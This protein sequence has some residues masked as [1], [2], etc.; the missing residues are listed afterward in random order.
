MSVDT[1][2]LWVRRVSRKWN[3]L[4]NGVKR[5]FSNGTP[6]HPISAALILSKQQN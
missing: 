4:T 2:A 6:K 5:H 1:K 3:N